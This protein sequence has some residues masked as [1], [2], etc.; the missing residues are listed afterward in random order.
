[1]SC[2][3]GVHGEVL[4]Q[5]LAYIPDETWMNINKNAEIAHNPPP[6][7][8]TDIVA[9]LNISEDEQ[10]KCKQFLDKLNTR[11]VTRS[12]MRKTVFRTE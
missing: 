2:D 12:T 1:M 4:V 6:S 9:R 3:G 11:V 5:M 10:K 8:Y 7:E